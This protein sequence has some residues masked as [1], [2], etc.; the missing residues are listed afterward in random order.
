M[1][2]VW[3]SAWRWILGPGNDLAPAGYRVHWPSCLAG[4]PDSALA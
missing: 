2:S 4:L 3:N 1:E